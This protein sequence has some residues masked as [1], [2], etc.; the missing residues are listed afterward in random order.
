M[1][2]SPYHLVLYDRDDEGMRRPSD[3][4]VLE[5]PLRSGAGTVRGDLVGNILAVDLD[6]V[7]LQEVPTELLVTQIT[8]AIQQVQQ[9][10]TAVRLHNIRERARRR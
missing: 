9:R 5:Q 7:R 6:R 3:P 10:A 2:G 4:A 8:E 1:S